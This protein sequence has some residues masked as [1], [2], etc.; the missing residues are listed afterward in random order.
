MLSP[1]RGRTGGVVINTD[2]MQVYRDLRIITARPTSRKR[3]QAPHRLYGHVDAAVNYSVGRFLMDAQARWRPPRGGALPI[4]VGGTGLYFKVLLSGLAAVP[5]IP[6]EIRADVRG[7]LADTGVAPLYTEL[8]ERDPVTAARLMPN[9]R[10]RI[11]PG[12]GGRAGD[13]ALADRLAP[14]RHAAGA[15]HREAVKLFLTPERKPWSS[16]S[17][18]GS[19]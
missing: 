15:R 5:P 18:P 19:T 10:S 6:A 8:W 12:A 4:F 7:R 11:S 2:S 14:G 17:K 16:A 9:D 1:W 13:R 3:Q